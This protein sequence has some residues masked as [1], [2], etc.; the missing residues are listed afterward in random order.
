MSRVVRCKNQRVLEGSDE[1]VVRFI[2]RNEILAETYAWRQEQTDE[3]L[4]GFLAFCSSLT[5]LWCK[6][7]EGSDATVVRLTA[8]NEIVA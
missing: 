5:I 6:M 7:L 1:Q 3:T 8:R 4:Q 2:A